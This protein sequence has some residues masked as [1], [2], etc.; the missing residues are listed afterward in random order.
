M[1]GPFERDDP[2]VLAE[3]RYRDRHAGRE[4]LEGGP[5]M[6]VSP[7]V[8]RWPCSSCNELVDMTREALDV[9][10]SFNAVLERRG[11]R[12]LPKRIPCAACKALDEERER[13]RR[14]PHEQQ[15]MAGVGEPQTKRRTM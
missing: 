15:R 12:P 4:D 2:E 10:K 3:R 8:E 14:R 13:E 7:T 5:A 9:H 6:R 11:E 1:R